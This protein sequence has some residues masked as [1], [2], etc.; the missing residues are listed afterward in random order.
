MVPN[1]RFIGCCWEDFEC[2][3]FVLEL[4][5]LNKNISWFG[6]NDSTARNSM[7]NTGSSLELVFDGVF[8]QVDSVGFGGLRLILLIGLMEKFGN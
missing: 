3:S 7:Q 8:K 6:D 1:E 4:F 5:G 2:C